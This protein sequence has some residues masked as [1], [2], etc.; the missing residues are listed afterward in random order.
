LKIEKFLM[1]H[2]NKTITEKELK[3]AIGGNYDEIAATVKQLVANNLLGPVKASGTNGR[4][5]PLY[6]KYR[7]VKPEEDYSGAIEKIKLLHPWFDH[8]AY[9]N[10]P[11][12]YLKYEKDIDGLSSYL[13]SHIEELETPMSINE[14]SLRIW[15]REKLLKENFTLL[16][17]I[18]KFKDRNINELNFY[19]TTEPFFEYIYRKCHEMNV[20][21]VENKDTW[22]TLRKVMGRM[23]RNVLLGREYHVLLYGEG[24]KITRRRGRLE[25]YNNEMLAGSSNTYYYFGDLDYEGI[26]IYLDLVKGN[27]NIKIQL[28]SELYELMVH[29]SD[30]I[31]LPVSNDK[32]DK[33]VDMGMFISGLFPETGLKIKKILGEGR[34]IPQE[35]IN[36]KIFTEL[37]KGKQ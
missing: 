13:W 6:N 33:D 10:K 29:E 16:N 11:Q 7:I 22:Y 5:P 26:S 17:S 3:E 32:R 9:F 28:C 18:L 14:R 15:G 2:E 4:K 34:Y 27:E 23:N 36:Y 21:I 8:Q 35:I 12:L 24:R 20:L 30:K 31:E 25:E 19:E 1:E 37:M